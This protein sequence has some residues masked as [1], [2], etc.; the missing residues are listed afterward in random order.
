MAEKLNSR[1][2]L[3]FC[4]R[5]NMSGVFYQTYI[6][7]F[8]FLFFLNIGFIFVMFY[9]VLLLNFP[10]CVLMYIHVAHLLEKRQYPWVKLF[11][12]ERKANFDIWETEM[13]QKSKYIE[14]IMLLY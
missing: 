3:P 11:I 8:F 1:N 6:S 12:R 4:F 10:I 5:L 14:C 13:W 9:F 2:L 7:S